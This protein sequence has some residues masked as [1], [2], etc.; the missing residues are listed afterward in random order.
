MEKQL[1]NHD[2]LILLRKQLCIFLFL[3]QNKN[4]QIY[5][6]KHYALLYQ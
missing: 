3:E 6:T 4:K 1:P 5:Y 2:F